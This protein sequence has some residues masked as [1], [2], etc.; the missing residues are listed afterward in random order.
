MTDEERQDEQQRKV[1]LP[2]PE[3]TPKPH[4]MASELTD[5]NLQKTENERLESAAAERTVGHPVSRSQRVAGRWVLAYALLILALAIVVSMV[6]FSRWNW[7]L[8]LLGLVIL[9]AYMLLISAPFWLASSTKA[10]QD[11]AAKNE[12]ERS[13]EAGERAPERSDV[14]RGQPVQDRRDQWAGQ[15]KTS[16]HSRGNRQGS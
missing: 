5:Q 12:L 2:H 14:G 16:T 11:E 15:K 10:A 6:L 3:E 4:P 9:F 7:T 1:E 8:F 13:P